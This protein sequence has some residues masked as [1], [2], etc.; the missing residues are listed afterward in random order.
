MQGY[1]LLHTFPGITQYSEKLADEYGE[2]VKYGGGPDFIRSL[3]DEL[4]G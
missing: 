3:L 4:S 1:P 2:I